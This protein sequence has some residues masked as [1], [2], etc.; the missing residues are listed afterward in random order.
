MIKRSIRKGCM[1]CGSP[2]LNFRQ[3]VLRCCLTCAESTREGLTKAGSGKF[4]EGFGEV[5]DVLAGGSRVKKENITTT[6][7][8]GLNRGE[9]K[10]FKRLDRQVKKGLLSPEEAKEGLEKFR[11]GLT[12]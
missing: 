12:K 6:M 11:G 10:I 9:K 5:I 8:R 4:K 1:Y 7:E 3:K 2:L